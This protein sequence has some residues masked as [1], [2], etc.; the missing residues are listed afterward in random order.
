M[1]ACASMAML[2]TEPKFNSASSYDIY[3]AFVS[4]DCVC[5]LWFKTALFI[6]ENIVSSLITSLLR[7][8]FLLGMTH[9]KHIAFHWHLI[10]KF[11]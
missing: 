7:S 10:Y 2:P 9:M 3:T 6:D 5:D 8:W 4:L 11:N 1:S